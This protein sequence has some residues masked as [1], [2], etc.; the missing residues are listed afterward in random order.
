[1]RSRGV[2][3]KLN[4]DGAYASGVVN[5]GDKAKVSALVTND[6]GKCSGITNINLQAVVFLRIGGIL[7]L[8]RRQPDRSAF[9][10]I[11]VHLARAFA[12]AFAIRGCGLLWKARSNAPCHVGLPFT[13]SAKRSC[14]IPRTRFVNLY[15]M[16]LAAHLKLLARTTL[17]LA[18]NCAD[19]R[20]GLSLATPAEPVSRARTFTRGKH[21]TRSSPRLKVIRATLGDSL[22]HP[23]P[24]SRPHL[25]SDRDQPSD[26][27]GRYF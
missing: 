18:V 11:A 26:A 16:N 24:R 23:H 3:N 22:H 15:H 2:L 12:S 7:M 10:P 13:S 27:R 14:P 8:V 25:T 20:Q 9:D 21:P 5:M 19:I 17:D 6:Y 1:M 4:G